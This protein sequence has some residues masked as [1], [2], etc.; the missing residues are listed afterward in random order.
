M[1]TKNKSLA[2]ANYGCS[3]RCQKLNS[4]HTRTL[5]GSRHILISSDNVNTR[6]SCSI[7]AQFSP[8]YWEQCMPIHQ[9]QFHDVNNRFYYSSKRQRRHCNLHRRPRIARHPAANG[10]TRHRLPYVTTKT[11]VKLDGRL[12]TEILAA[13]YESKNCRTMAEQLI[14]G[15]FRALPYSLSGLVRVANEQHFFARF[16]VNG[17]DMQ[18]SRQFSQG[19]LGFENTKTIHDDGNGSISPTLWQNL[20]CD[21]KNHVNLQLFTKSLLWPLFASERRF[22]IFA[23]I[24]PH[25]TNLRHPPEQPSN[26]MRVHHSSYTKMA[27]EHLAL[28]LMDP[29][30]V[31]KLKVTK[32]NTTLPGS[33]I[34]VITCCSCM[35]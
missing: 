9:S 21:S 15:Y 18:Y 20:Q 32:P 24:V 12:L 33:G 19:T 30:N 25:N 6:T 5:L 27:Q 28:V 31:R 7:S 10:G 11:A 34:Y 13:H 4:G 8:F 16:A 35:Y 2:C 23:G 1:Q 3:S 26:K 17:E 22:V 14:Q 29:A